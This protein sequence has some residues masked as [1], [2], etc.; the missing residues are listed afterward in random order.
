MVQ[1]RK[2]N[3]YNLRNFVPRKQNIDRFVRKLYCNS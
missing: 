3:I 1:K 2:V